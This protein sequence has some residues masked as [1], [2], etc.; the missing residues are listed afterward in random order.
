VV[1]CCVHIMYNGSCYRLI[2]RPNVLIGGATAWSEFE[3]IGKS[4]EAVDKDGRPTGMR[5]KV[6]SKTVRCEGIQI[7]PTDDAGHIL[8]IP[9][10]LVEHFPQHGPYLGIYA[11]VTNEGSLAVGES[12]RL[13]ED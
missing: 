5:L 9:K 4:L 12:V 6:I 1:A 2:F 3:W 13:C 7:D 8:D 11:I 10:L